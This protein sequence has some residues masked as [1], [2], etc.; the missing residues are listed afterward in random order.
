MA[1]SRQEPSYFKFPESPWLLYPGCE[2]FFEGPRECRAVLGTSIIRHGVAFSL[3]LKKK[4]LQHPVLV[5]YPWVLSHQTVLVRSFENCSERDNL[6]NFSK[7]SFARAIRSVGYIRLT[8]DGGLVFFFPVLPGAPG[9]RHISSGLAYAS[10]FS[11]CNLSGFS[12]CWTCVKFVFGSAGRVDEPV[13]SIS[14]TVC[15]QD[16]QN[17][18]IIIRGPGFGWYSR[19]VMGLKC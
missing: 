12:P 7:P 16:V 10:F 14:T 3:T 4:M 13:L 6:T 15:W 17:F 19:R 18:S 8:I 5:R 11:P 9:Y 2:I 1:V